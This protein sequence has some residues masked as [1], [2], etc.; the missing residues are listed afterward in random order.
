[1]AGGPSRPGL[2]A[3][4]PIRALVDRSP[5]MTRA[6]CDVSQ[7]ATDCS[8]LVGVSGRLRNA[9]VHGVQAMLRLDRVT[10]SV[11]DV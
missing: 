7:P 1:M 2:V 6:V 4:A 9:R 10:R 11:S 8:A 3:P 5:V